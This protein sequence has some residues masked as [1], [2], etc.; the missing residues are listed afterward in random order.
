MRNAEIQTDVIPQTMP[1]NVIANESILA[2]R[3]RTSRR[4]K[5][6]KDS[7]PN[8]CPATEPKVGHAD[9]HAPLDSSAKKDEV[10]VSEVSSGGSVLVDKINE[11]LD[12]TIEAHKGRIAALED[13][14]KKLQEY[15]NPREEKINLVVH[16]Q[17]IR[18]AQTMLE[19]PPPTIPQGLI[20][21]RPTLETI[22]EVASTMEKGSDHVSPEL[23]DAPVDY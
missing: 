7:M 5:N 18:E 13:L 22:P 20:S 9:Q 15:P 1:P 16:R 8:I 3:K 6:S 21:L 23:M 4:K 12:A 14:P 2:K 11:T 19:G 17:L 10:V